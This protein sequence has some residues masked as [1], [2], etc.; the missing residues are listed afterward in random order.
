MIQWITKW[1]TANCP[2]ELRG[3]WH[4]SGESSPDG[5]FDP[6]CPVRRECFRQGREYAERRGVGCWPASDRRDS[7]SAEDLV[8][9]E[10][11]SSALIHR[12]NHGSTAEC[13]RSR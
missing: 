11:D 5:S 7:A 8:D 10:A 1:S 12:S 3:A 13:S 4:L 6:E 2:A 9:L